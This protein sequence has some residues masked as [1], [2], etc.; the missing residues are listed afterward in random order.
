M[1]NKAQEF[2]EFPIQRQNLFPK[3]LRMEFFEPKRS[4]KEQTWHT[5]DIK[6]NSMVLHKDS[7]LTLGKNVK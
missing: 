3:I 1:C 2:M 7:T 4:A 5:E 6:L